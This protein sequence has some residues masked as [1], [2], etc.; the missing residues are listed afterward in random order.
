M[1]VSKEQSIYGIHFARF[2][3]GFDKY[4]PPSTPNPLL[5]F[6]IIICS[7]VLYVL[8]M[9]MYI[10]RKF[11]KFSPLPRMYDMICMYISMIRKG[12]GGGVCFLKNKKNFIIE[13]SNSFGYC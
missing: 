8:G 10:Q 13:S 9:I 3:K 7:L 12:Y 6:F 1:I 5:K 11:F 2:G 4:C